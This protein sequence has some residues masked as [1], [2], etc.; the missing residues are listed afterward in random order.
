[1][2]KIQVDLPLANYAYWFAEMALDFFK[3]GATQ[4]RVQYSVA[5]TEAWANIGLND[6]QL[7]TL[8]K[9]PAYLPS[10]HIE[11]LPWP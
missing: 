1:L 5:L 4:V 2:T 8:G 9:N 11:T 3:R 6:P 10:D 7:A